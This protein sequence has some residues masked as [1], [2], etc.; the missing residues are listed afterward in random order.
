MMG[1]FN[2]VLVSNWLSGRPY[3]LFCCNSGPPW[4][5]HTHTVTHARWLLALFLKWPL[6]GRSELG[7]NRPF[8]LCVC[9]CVCVGALPCHSFSSD[10]PQTSPH[11]HTHTQSQSFTF[12]NTPDTRAVPMNL[13][14]VT[15]ILNTF[16]H[17]VEENMNGAGVS[18]NE[19]KGV[20]RWL[21]RCSDWF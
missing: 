6:R 16:G 19:L 7:T 8:S 5:R 15:I 17:L 20:D 3:F 11:T 2:L 1:H 18:K 4:C 21:L 10:H 13:I 14:N 12:N 9:V